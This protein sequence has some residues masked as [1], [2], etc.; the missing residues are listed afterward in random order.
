MTKKINESGVLTIESGYYTQ[1]PEFGNL[2][3]EALRL[4]YTIFGYEAS[5]G[6]NGKDRE[7]EQAENIQK[8]IEHAPKGKIIIHCGYAHAFENGYP[9]WGK[10]MAGRLK[11]NLKIDPFTI[12][13]TMF[14]EKSDDQYE[15]EFI[16]LNT[17]NYPVVLADQH[18]RIYNGSNEVKQTDIVVIHPKTQFMDSRPDWVGKGNYRYTIPDSGISQYPVLILAYRAGE[19][20]KNGIPSDV[21]EVTGRDSGKSLF[22]AKGKYEIVLKNKN[23]NIMDKYEIE[24][25]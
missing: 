10:A 11:E 2:V 22:L 18:D 4:G 25:K 1:E 19:F 16:K 8:F 12:D 14:L 21:I 17:T 9:A 24:V 13:Q 5:E 6:K 20:D 3:S 7:I 15:H 23:Y